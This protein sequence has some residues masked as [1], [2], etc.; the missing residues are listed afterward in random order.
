MEFATLIAH[1]IFSFIV[2]L[3]IIV[4]IHEFGHYWIAKKF[5]VKIEEFS[6][7][8]G[9]EIFGWNDKSGTRWKVSLVPLGGYVKMFGDESA[10]STPDSEKLREFSEDEKSVSFYYQKLYK[11]FL[12]VLGGP[13]ANFLTAIVILTFFFNYYGRPET[14]PVVDTVLETSAAEEIGIQTGDVITNL[15]GKNITRFEQLKGIVALHPEMPLSIE[16][17]RAG[18]II[19][20]EITPK[21]LETEDVFGDKARIGIIGISAVAAEYQ[22]LG[23]VDSVFASVEETYDISVKTLQAV[24]QMIT[25]DRSAKDI[26]GI[27]RIADYSG[28]SVDQGLKMVFWFMAIISINLGLV[29]LFPI[30]MLDGGHLFFY[31][32]EAVRGKPLSEKTQEYLFRFGFLVLISLMLFATF[33]D[34]RHFNVISFQ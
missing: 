34:L 17:D 8:F 5:G 25:G 4:F 14:K 24:G 3:S 10:A 13:L 29:N 7:G 9:K 16:Y 31:I 20:A 11:R 1:N 26:S 22:E 19:K 12:I 33:N 27:L 32:I 15:N 21:V 2:I 28:K 18:E 30:P 23:M 6:I